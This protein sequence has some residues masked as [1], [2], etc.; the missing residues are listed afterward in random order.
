MQRITDK[1]IN[2]QEEYKRILESRRNS[3][4]SSFDIKRWKRMLKHFRG[5][6]LIDL[7]CFDSLL[8][9]FAKDWYPESIVYGLDFVDDV[10]EQM[11]KIEPVVNYVRGNVYHTYF[12]DNYFDYI[13]A[14]ELVE[15]LEKPYEF[16]KEVF[17]ILKPGGIFVLS[18]P[19]EETKKGE[20]DK[21]R[22]LWSFDKKDIFRMLKPYG[23]VKIE[24]MG[25]NYFP[26][27]K[28]HFP[29]ILGFCQKAG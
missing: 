26:I 20:V 22:H 27:Y 11:K 5:G 23:Y 14:G 19:L 10:I 29:Y 1:N 7:G 17:R 8:P 16:L 24:T 4:Y 13:T 18:T 6:I 2:T 12:Q 3:K 21:E 28:Y 25:S 15:H 9:T